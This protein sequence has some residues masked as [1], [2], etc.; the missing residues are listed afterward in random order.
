MK[1]LA[2]LTIVMTG[3]GAVFILFALDFVLRWLDEQPDSE[4]LSEN[5]MGKELKEKQLS[6]QTDKKP[7]LAA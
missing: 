6:E 1:T 7:K 2:G 3:V 4:L 5:Q